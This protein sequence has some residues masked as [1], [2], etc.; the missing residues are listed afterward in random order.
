MTIREA[1]AQAKNYG[2]T[3]SDIH[4]CFMEALTSLD[5]EYRVRLYNN[6]S[7]NE[8]DPI[9]TREEFSQIAN[10]EEFLSFYGRIVNSRFDP[11]CDWFQYDQEE[12][13]YVSY[14]DEN[15]DETPIAKAYLNA[16]WRSGVIEDEDFAENFDNEMERL[17][18]ELTN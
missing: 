11:S 18:G 17:V 4:E 16:T 13:G 7:K 5:I 8:I 10:N 1:V 15:I 9:L 3:L 14:L 2:Y 12:S 6:F